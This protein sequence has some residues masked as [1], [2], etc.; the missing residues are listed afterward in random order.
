MAIGIELVSQC[1]TV[2]GVDVFQESVNVLL[3][4]LSVQIRE[5][6]E[7]IFLVQIA[8]AYAQQALQEECQCTCTVRTDMAVEEQG[9]VVLHAVKYKLQV[10]L[11][12]VLPVLNAA[13]IVI[14]VVD[15]YV[16]NVLTYRRF[17]NVERFVA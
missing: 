12:E 13:L 4:T 5:R 11:V 6:C 7:L 3:V 1:L 14:L 8:F 10:L 15:A 9:L 2:Q 16:G 17:I